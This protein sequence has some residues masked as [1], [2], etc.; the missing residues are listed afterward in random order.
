MFLKILGSI[1][2][3][4]F[5]YC[6]FAAVVIPREKKRVGEFQEREGI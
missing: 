6:A 5:L 1:F 4:A 2:A 3:I